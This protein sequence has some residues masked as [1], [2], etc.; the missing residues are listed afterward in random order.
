LTACF[1][2]ANI[3]RLK[4]GLRTTAGRLA[5]TTIPVKLRT[6][7]TI[8]GVRRGPEVKPDWFSRA[9][10][11]SRGLSKRIVGIEID[12]LV[13]R[14]TQRRLKRFKNVTIICG[15][16]LKNLPEDGTVF[17]FYNPFDRTWVAALKDQLT[18]LV[19]SGE[20]KTIF[21]YNCAHVDVFQQDPVWIVEELAPDPRSRF[22][23]PWQ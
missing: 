10:S 15:D 9:S 16:A 14:M 20:R 11:Y 2:T 5:R 22:S 12:E 7:G 23:I 1:I 17:Y 4:R 3:P 13:P 8:G 18:I 21:Y 6:V 19:A